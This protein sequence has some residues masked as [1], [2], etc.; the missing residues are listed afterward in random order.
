MT[1]K[2][3]ATRDE[4]RRSILDRMRR[5]GRILRNPD[6]LH[7]TTDRSASEFWI[8]IEKLRAENRI[9]ILGMDLAIPERGPPREPP[10]FD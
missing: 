5:G 9:E 10:T 4:R 8:G 7:A 1:A 3:Q 6:L 2:R